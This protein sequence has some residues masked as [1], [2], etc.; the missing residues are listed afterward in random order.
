MNVCHRHDCAYDGSCEACNLQDQLTEAN[1]DLQHTRHELIDRERE[2]E[3]LQQAL[4]HANARIER[5]ESV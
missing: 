2:C 4:N 3:R 1:N 5:L